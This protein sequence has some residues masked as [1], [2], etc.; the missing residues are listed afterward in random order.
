MSELA[1]VQ[2]AALRKETPEVR[3]SGCRDRVSL[4]ERVTLFILITLGIQSVLYFMT[5]WLE[6][7]H[8][9]SGLLFIILTFAIGWG[10]F[11][12]LVNW[13]YFFFIKGNSYKTPPEGLAADVFMTAMPGE[14]YDM[15]EK[16]L[17][18][19]SKIRYPHESYLLDG[20]NDP[21]LRQLCSRL[22]IN[23]LDCT[24]I[25]G[26]KA[27]KIN[28]AMKV[29]KGEFILVLDPDHLPEPDFFDQVLGNFSDPE[30]GFVQVVQ[31]YYNQSESVVARASAEQTYNFYGPTMMG[32]HGLGTPVA[33]GA[34]CT[35]RREALESIGGH[36]VHL[37]EDLVTSLRLHAKKWKSTY[38][39]QR[40]SLGLVPGDLGSYFK[41]QLKWSTGMFQAFSGEYISRF[42]ALPF[43]QKLHYFFSGTYYLEG[44][45]TAITCILP[46][47]FLFFG[48]W[49]V[50]MDFGEF[51]LHLTPYVIISLIIGIYVQRFY[52]H[53]DEKGIPW[54]GM[55]LNKGTWVIYLLGF[56]FWMTR[57]KVPYL[58]TPK[59]S[60]RGIFTG[61]VVPHIAVVLLSGC[62][63]A[64]S[65]L[66]YVRIESGVWVMIFFASLNIVTML[67]T[68][69]IAHLDL[70]K[71]EGVK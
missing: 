18:A 20:G 33:I 37:A 53:P 58:P 13:F 3:A 16:S 9:R 64:Y 7:G 39:P 55:A 42:T 41:Q 17:E 30:V 71:K 34:N 44:L 65:L 51:L 43:A 11:R 68:I 19:I 28:H 69:I 32:M 38:V 15:F 45:A 1:T 36:A 21:K 46:I 4:G 5:W 8:R 10:V 56:Y 27:G 29:S 48:L 24:N 59:K 22:G 66:T 60:Q 2:P 25:E 54:R 12:S 63:I 47:L 31:G 6:P 62:A 67:P 50:E 61:L 70:F 14:P 49:A 52:R 26:A 35:F 23:H 57:T 40:M